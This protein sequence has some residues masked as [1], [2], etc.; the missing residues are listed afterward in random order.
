MLHP[1]H[2]LPVTQ[3]MEAA[4][5]TCHAEFAVLPCGP[6]QL[7]ELLHERLLWKRRQQVCAVA[8]VRVVAQP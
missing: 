3:A 6:V 8:R 1:S 7:A 2:D 5:K 4:R